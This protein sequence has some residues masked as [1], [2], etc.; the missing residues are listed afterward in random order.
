MTINTSEA[1]TPAGRPAGIPLD[2]GFLRPPS[3]LE[4]ALG[5]EWARLIRGIFTNPLSVIGLII[6]TGFIVVGLLAPVLAPPPKPGANPYQIPRD[7]FLPEPKPPGTPWVKNAPYYVPAWYSLTGNE[8]WVHLWGTTSGQYDI[9]Y[10]VIWGSRTALMIGGIV[11]LS[12]ALIGIVVGATAGFYGGW[13]DEVLMRVVEIFAAIPTFFLLLSFVAFF[14][15][16]LYI[17]MVI[18]GVTGWVGYARFTRTEFLRL[19]QQDFV[20]AAV[21]CGLPLR[22]ILFRQMLPNGVAPVLVE[23]SFGVAAAILYEATLSFLG[24]GLVDEPSWGQ[25]LSA[26]TTASGG[27]NWWVALYPGLA[28]F[29]TVFA[30]NLVGEALRDAIDPY[31]SRGG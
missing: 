21:A 27:F 30:Y 26:A 8:E 4:K 19:R 3:R 23:A 31:T 20:Q 10:G 14:P 16:N 17:M 5:P 28:I 7:G 18:I 2:E 22:S 12:S 9:F 13:I 11:V 25:M 24:L 1:V 29:L 6:V 15:R